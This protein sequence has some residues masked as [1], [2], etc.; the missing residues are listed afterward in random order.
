[1]DELCY[2]FRALCCEFFYVQMHLYSCC[3]Y[4]EIPKCKRVNYKKMWPMTLYIREQRKCVWPLPKMMAHRWHSLSLLPQRPSHQHQTSGNETFLC[5]HR[6]F[7][8]ISI[9]S[10]STSD[11]TSK[12][13]T[14]RFYLV[15]PRPHFGGYC[16]IFRQPTPS[17]LSN[18]HLRFLQCHHSIFHILA[19]FHA[20]LQCFDP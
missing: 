16:D 7:L 2:S 18:F 15:R 19:H 14:L 20:L 6:F 5:C 3:F 11:N 8:P 9:G 1:M 4:Y 10:L 12:I 13:Y 17:I